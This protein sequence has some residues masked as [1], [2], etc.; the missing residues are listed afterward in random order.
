MEMDGLMLRSH[1]LAVW[2]FNIIY[3]NGWFDVEISSSDS[4]A[5]QYN[6]WKWVV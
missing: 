3:G 4:M 2:Q 6:L 5:I 1:H